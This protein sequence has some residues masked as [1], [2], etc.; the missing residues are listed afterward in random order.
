[1]Q[2]SLPFGFLLFL[3]SVMLGLSP[4]ILLNSFPGF[5]RSWV[6]LQPAYLS[7]WPWDVLRSHPACLARLSGGSVLEAGLSSQVGAGL[8]AQISGETGTGEPSP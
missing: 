7:W 5:L 3:G 4:R 6:G 2:S 1:M 8:P